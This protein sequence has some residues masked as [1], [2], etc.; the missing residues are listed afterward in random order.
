M[1][2]KD[3][4]APSPCAQ[5]LQAESSFV[6][7]PNSFLCTVPE[8]AAEPGSTARERAPPR[9]DLEIALAVPLDGQRCSRFLSA[10]KGTGHG[11]TSPGCERRGV[12]MRQLAHEYSIGEPETSQKS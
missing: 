4:S 9:L 11:T 6:G 2:G 5:F 8:G 10:E 3:E 1:N 7:S 12:A